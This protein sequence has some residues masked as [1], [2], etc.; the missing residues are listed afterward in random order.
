MSCKFASRPHNLGPSSGSSVGRVDGASLCFELHCPSNM[1]VAGSLPFASLA[2][3]APTPLFDLAKATQVPFTEKLKVVKIQGDG[4]C[5]F[6]AIAQGLARNKGIFLG[7]EVEVQE[8]DQLRGAVTEGLCRSKKR[9]A[10]FKE[11]LVSIQTEDSLD[12]YCRRLQNPS[13]WG[14]EP[15][16][17]VLSKMLRVPIYVYTKEQGFGAG[18][19]PLYKVG[20]KFA[21]AG[22]DWK[23]RKPVKLLYSNGNH[24]D[25]L[26]G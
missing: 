6:R 10:D 13:F 16:L 3:C 23:K 12:N 17:L 19:S 1:P 2:F 24:Y 5:M 4:R 26:T 22:K 21:K 25:L 20:E 14:G 8:A 11:A 15:E 18:Y 7:P 9:R